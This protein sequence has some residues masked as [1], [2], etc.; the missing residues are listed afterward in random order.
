MHIL[1]LG[2]CEDRSPIRIADRLALSPVSSAAG[3][4]SRYMYLDPDPGQIHRYDRIAPGRE[5]T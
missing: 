2:A 5:D 4:S 3:V 1:N